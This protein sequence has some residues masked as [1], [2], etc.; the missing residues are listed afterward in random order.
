[1]EE[2]AKCGNENFEL[3][4]DS[5]KDDQ[6]VISQL[7]STFKIGVKVKQINRKLSPS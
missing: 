5:L 1:M 2:K 7:E 6:K 3:S 4:L